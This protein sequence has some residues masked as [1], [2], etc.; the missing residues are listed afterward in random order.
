LPVG[1]GESSKIVDP[2]LSDRP[3]KRGSKFHQP[4]LLK[5]WRIFRL[6]SAP[7]QYTLYCS[8]AAF[9]KVSTRKTGRA[10]FRP[11]TMNNPPILQSSDS[12]SRYQSRPPKGIVT[13]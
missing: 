6:C 7:Q 8:A 3:L 11:I 4:R 12:P 2:Q 9:L 1:V 5:R 13:I 10:M